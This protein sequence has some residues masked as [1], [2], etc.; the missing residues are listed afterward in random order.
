MERVIV[1]V[2]TSL[3]CAILNVNGQEKELAWGLKGGANYSTLWDRL[4]IDGQPGIDYQFKTG[5]YVGG[6]ANLPL[7]Q[8]WEL[9]PELLF[10]QRNIG[11]E[12]GGFIGP[13]VISDNY[14]AVR[15]ETLLDLPIIFRYKALSKIFLEAGPQFGFLLDQKEEV[16]ESPYEDRELSSFDYDKFD[17][18]L[19]VGVGYS[20]SPQFALSLRYLQ[21]LIKRDR[22]V[23]SQMFNLGVEYVF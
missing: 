7:S 23:N 3:L 6:L 8:K 22:S 10:S 18:G 21:G 4:E 13:H 19:T 2:V 14:K 16:K 9:Q 20:F 5:F 11:I 17:A 15:T 12:L 1:A